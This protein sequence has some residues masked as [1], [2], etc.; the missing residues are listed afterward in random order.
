[1][2]WGAWSQKAFSITKI[3]LRKLSLKG[4]PTRLVERV[5]H[6]IGQTIR[7]QGQRKSSFFTKKLEDSDTTLSASASTLNTKVWGFT[8][9]GVVQLSVMAAG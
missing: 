3:Y 7:E 4:Q 1:M 6:S 8:C 2:Q 9:G 5:L